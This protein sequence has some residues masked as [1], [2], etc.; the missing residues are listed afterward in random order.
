MKKLLFVINVDWY[1]CLH[2]LARAKAAQNEGFEIHLATQNTKSKQIQE[3]ENLGFKIHAIELSRKSMSLTNNI[4]TFWQL[5]TLIRVL[6]PDLVHS[7]TV[8][9]NLF[10][11]LICKYLSIPQVMSV[12][13]LGI[14]FSSR[15]IKARIS[16]G[17]VTT[18][19]RFIAKRKSKYKILFE[20]KDD[21]TRFLS[22]NIGTEKNLQV[23]A[24]AGV[25]LSEYL[26]TPKQIKQEKEII[27]ILFAARMLWSK[28][29]EQLI[30]AVGLVRNNGVAL[31]LNVAGIIDTDSCDAIPLDKI[32]QWASSNT[33]NWLGQVS[34]MVTLIQDADIICLPTQ[35]GEG[36]PR[37]LI[38]A[39]AIGRPIITTNVAGCRDIV[40][41]NKSGF[42]V[43][44]NDSNAIAE[45]INIL[46]H[47]DKMRY[48]FGLEAR[49]IT[50]KTFCQNIVIK[51]TLDIYKELL[52]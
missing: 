44:I 21:R 3:L 17:I 37:I 24:G 28:G 52:S 41:N 15:T 51:S 26:Y 9:P 13:G 33:I 2:W 18:L 39:A 29:L 40:E 6:K 20:N 43:P 19:Y 47:D 46:M 50:E 45:K 23:I 11:G 30:S 27:K 10:V 48:D 34:D 25:N 4:K 35:Y 5:F 42:I 36:V 32:N 49:I 7:I 12:T 22:E 38:E 8:K 16:R 14:T 31:E 1:F